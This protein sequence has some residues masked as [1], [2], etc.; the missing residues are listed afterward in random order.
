M[1]LAIGMNSGSSFDGIDV[2][3]VELE[4]GTD[5]HP[6]KPRFVT[7]L[8]HRWPDPVQEAV[9]AAFANRL[10]IFELTRLHYVTGAVYATAARRILA[11]L[12]PSATEVEVI[13]VDG[14]TI[15]QEPPAFSR[16]ADIADDDIVGRWLDGPYPCGLQ[17]GEPAVIAAS[18]DLPVVWNFRPSDHAVGGTGAP[19]MQYLD[20]LLARELGPIMTLNI[21]G[22]AN[23]QL[24]DPDRSKMRAFDTGPGNVM[25]DH[26]MKRLYGQRYDADG[27]LAARGSVDAGLLDELRQ[28]PFFRRR[29]P[30]SAW[31]LDF[32]ADYA[33]RVIDSNAGMHGEDLVAT[34]T[35]FSA[36]AI[37]SSLEQHIPSAGR[38][39]VLIASGGGVRNPTLMRMIAQALPKG[40]E[41]R[42]SDDFGIPAQYKEAVKFAAL[43]FSSYH[44]IADNIPAASGA[45]RYAVLGKLVQPP[46]RAKV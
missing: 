31:R 38:P 25:I 29:P 6:S 40:L 43:G 3:A 26:A 39:P 10:S 27:R 41:V 12:G 19:L 28:H 14:Q 8:E 23:C 4:A 44:G 36:W 34:L 11:E 13:G 18:C 5:G 16:Y 1:V 22:I 33:D 45:S 15:Y 17:I 35:A 32:G 21:G 20:F 30:R 24:A 42:A 46:G 37:S 2:A 7:G 9:L